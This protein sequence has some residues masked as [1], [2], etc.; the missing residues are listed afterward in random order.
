M[1]PIGTSFSKF[2]RL[3]RD[4]CANLGK[5]ISLSTSGADTELDKTVIERLGDPLV[6][7]LRNSIDHGIE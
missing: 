3:V 6:H 1:L 7:L 5:Q 4:L 2:R